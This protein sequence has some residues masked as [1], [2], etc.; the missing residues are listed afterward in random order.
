MLDYAKKEFELDKKPKDSDVSLRDHLMSIFD[1]TGFMPEEL[2]NPEPSKAIDY[3]LEYFHQL[4]RTRQI[5]M[6]LNPITFTEIEAWK[7]LFHIELAV[8]EIDVIKQLDLIYL[9]VQAED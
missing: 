5:G 3:L 7:R 8:W 4:S 6:A 2:N 9:S 1:N